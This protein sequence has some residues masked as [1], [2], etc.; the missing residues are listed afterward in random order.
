MTAGTEVT[1]WWSAGSWAAGKPFQPRQGLPLGGGGILSGW[2]GSPAPAGR[3]PSWSARPGPGESTAAAMERTP[4]WSA[5]VMLI[6]V[7]FL[8]AHLGAAPLPQRKAFSSPTWPQEHWMQEADFKATGARPLGRW[9][10]PLSPHPSDP[11]SCPNPTARGTVEQGRG[12]KDIDAQFGVWAA[13]RLC[14][15]PARPQ[16]RGF[17]SPLP[18]QGLSL[19]A[20]HSCL[21]V[22]MEPHG[23][24]LPACL[25]RQNSG[26]ILSSHPTMVGHL[27]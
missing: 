23:P 8:K 12:G 6:P 15:V 24:C 25:C 16:E 20:K 10:W 14:W 22:L 5:Q 11:W 18:H 27:L 26:Q 9:F 1:R 2:T 17:I 19:E 7:G 13:P 4:A 3:M 21:V